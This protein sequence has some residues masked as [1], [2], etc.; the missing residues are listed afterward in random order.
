MLKKRLPIG[1]EDFKR[2]IDGDFYYVDKTA[3][4]SELHETGGQ[5]NL[6]L[7]PR[8]FGKTL[9]LSTLRYFY[10]DTGD[11]TQNALRRALFLGQDRIIRGLYA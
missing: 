7:R 8:R 10:E 4:I 2:I 11:A 1:F 5:V 9:M 3:L 6:F